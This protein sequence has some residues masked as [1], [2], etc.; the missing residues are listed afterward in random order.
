[1]L[2]CKPYKDASFTI[3]RGQIIDDWT[4]DELYSA[5]E[6]TFI[7]GSKTAVFYTT[8]V[9]NLVIIKKL[10]RKEPPKLLKDHNK[11]DIR[12]YEFPP[13]HFLLYHVFNRKLQQYIEGDLVHYN[14]RWFFEDNNPKKFELFKEPFAV[15]TL[16]E[17]EA[18][19]VVCMTPLVVSIL[20]F[21]FEWL[22]TLK[23]LMVCLFI[24]K[25]YF[26]VKKS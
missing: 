17:L 1:M 25:T 8:A 21:G 18:G 24:F 9:Y 22:P 20:I 6:R 12:V 10:D 5:F 7:P 19:F 14:T 3:N 16:G 4:Y 11:L 2:I 23:D 15:L 13:H 26:E